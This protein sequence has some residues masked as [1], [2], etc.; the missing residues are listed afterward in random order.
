MAIPTPAV[1]V[2]DAGWLVAAAAA[3]LAGWHDLHLRSLGHRTAW[4]DGLW[5]T[6]ERVP[7][8]FFSAIAVR[9]GAHRDVVANGTSVTTWTAACD[10]WSDLDL[11]GSGYEHL[12]DQPWMSRPAGPV[13]MPTSPQ[14]LAIE[15]V[16]DVADL[17]RFEATAAAGFE[18]GAVAPHTWHGMDVL[19]DPRLAMWLGSIDGHPVAVSMGFADAGVLGIYGVATVPRMRRRGL[20]RAMTAHT[21]AATPD[22]PAVLQPS[23]MAEPLYRRLGFRRFG[24]FR[25]WARAGDA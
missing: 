14:G 4:R 3:N 15:R 13:D 7:V 5:L 8:I 16:A 12:S 22:I 25:S 24:A 6:P 19:S 23:T 1:A 17:V 20:A 21:L 18:A 11:A 9:P 2:P 10:P